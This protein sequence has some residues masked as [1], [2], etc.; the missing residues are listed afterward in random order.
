MKYPEQYKTELLNAIQGIN[1]DGVNEAIEMF[2]E[3]RA[4]GGRIFICASGPRANAA[5]YLLRDTLK[6]S[7]L[8]QQYRFRIFV[9]N[10]DR[11]GA[12]STEDSVRELTFTEQLKNIAEHGDVLVAISPSANAPD[13]VNAIEFGNR[14]GCLSISITGR[15][16]GKLASISNLAILIPASH[17]GS[18]EDAHM[19]I[20]HIIGDYFVNLGKG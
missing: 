12:G 3:A 13:V 18:V 5:A 10:D 20:C 8:T 19:V 4:R 6:G 2:R 11:A 16:G 15:N 14:V 9:L 7:G 17:Q 1:L